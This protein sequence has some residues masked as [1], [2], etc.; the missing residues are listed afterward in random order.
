MDP[1]S[2]DNA[3][4]ADNQQETLSEFFY[5]TGFCCGEMSCSLLKLS[6]RKSK[7]GGVYYTPDITI[8][9]AD[10]SHLQEVN[11]LVCDSLGVISTIKGGYNLSFRGKKRV[12]KVLNFFTKYPPIAGDLARSRLFLVSKSIE[13]LE[14][15]RGYRRPASIQV[16][17][18]DIR[19]QF[20]YVKTR[21]VPISKFRQQVFS[22][23]EI[24]HF[25]SG[26]LDAEGSVGIKSSG[27]SRQPFVAVAMKD[28]K[29]VKLFERFFHLGHIHLRPKEKMFHYEIGA[30]AE[31]LK[32][33]NVFTK[34]FPV[35]LRKTKER[36][37]KVQRILNDYTLDP[38]IRRGMI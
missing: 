8:S 15:Q 3:S 22:R 31:V 13:V 18:E 35:K 23:D 17:L 5:F 20:S 28:E 1:M 9:N 11:R 30:K 25:L 27:K 33:L 10:Y 29:I 32:I 2:T 26:I 6:N 34:V 19:T 4:G 24:G 12:K 37:K 38:R 14:K 21:A 7:K 36:I 16:N